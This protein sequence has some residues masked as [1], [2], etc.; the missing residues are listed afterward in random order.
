M[1]NV[2]QAKD[3]TDSNWMKLYIALAYICNKQKSSENNLIVAMPL[4]IYKQMIKNFILFAT[5]E[6]WMHLYDKLKLYHDPECRMINDR[7]KNKMDYMNETVI[8]CLNLSE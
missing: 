6:D 8:Y 2:G 5:I 1:Y 3:L 4:F 7:I